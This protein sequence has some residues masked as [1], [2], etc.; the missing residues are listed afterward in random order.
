MKNKNLFTLSL[1]S[2]N[3][4]LHL[5]SASIL[6]LENLRE[7]KNSERNYFFHQTLIEVEQQ[8]SW[9]N[10]FCQRPNDYMLILEIDGVSIGCMG[11]RL[12]NNNAWDVYNVILGVASFGKQGHMSRALTAMLQVARNEF[13]FPIKLKV[14]RSNPALNW[15][16]KNGFIIE[17]E[18]T[19]HFGLL[20]QTQ[21]SKE[22]R[23]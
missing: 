11:I 8:R 7:W 6:D 21:T 14:L 16:Q 1:L 9:F 5:R 12:L 4:T 3:K 18:E 17:Y 15:Y 22:F 2:G 10:T 20:Y 23:S 19:D 13:D